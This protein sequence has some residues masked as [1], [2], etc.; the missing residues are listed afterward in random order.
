MRRPFVLLAALALGLTGGLRP[1]PA[2]AADVAATPDPAPL[3]AAIDRHVADG[4]A[5]RG[6][7]PAPRADDASFFRR[8]NL[9][10]AGRIPLP[11]E[12]RTFA[13]DTDP[14]KRRK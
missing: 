3:T 5:A 13:A 1:R 6:V 8:V 4:L 14:D 10:L 11:A 12:V 2:G 9:A 7:K